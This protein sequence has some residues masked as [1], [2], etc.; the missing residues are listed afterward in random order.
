MTAVSL[1]HS[2]KLQKSFVVSVCVK[3]EVEKN[4]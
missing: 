4:K 1:H 2:Y 3:E